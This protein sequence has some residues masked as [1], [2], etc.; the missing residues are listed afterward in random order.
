MSFSGDQEGGMRYEVVASYA[1]NWYHVG[2]Y[3][4]QGDGQKERGQVSQSNNL[5]V[6]ILDVVIGLNRS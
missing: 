2:E 6:N 5:L 1:S 4:K 3:A